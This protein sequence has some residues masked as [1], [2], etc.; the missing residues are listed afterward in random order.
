VKKVAA[1]WGGK[2]DGTREI[3]VV[4]AEPLEKVKNQEKAVYCL[5]KSLF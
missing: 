2:K 1:K 4:C 5:Q 3:S